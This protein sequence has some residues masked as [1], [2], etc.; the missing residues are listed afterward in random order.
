M[1]NLYQTLRNS[2]PMS[3]W[4]CHN[5]LLFERQDGQIQSIA[6]DMYVE[7]LNMRLYLCKYCAQLFVQADD[8]IECAVYYVPMR[9]NNVNWHMSFVGCCLQMKPKRNEA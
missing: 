4:R 8:S 6:V 7:L 2:I 1:P 5:K 3:C 9:T